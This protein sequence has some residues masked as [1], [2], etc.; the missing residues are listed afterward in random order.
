MKFAGVDLHKKTISICVCD[1]ARKIVDRYRLYCDKPASISHYFQNLGE[2]RM[3]VEAT[4]SYEWFVKLVEPHADKV[5]LAHPGKLRVI[6]ESTRKS[7]K[8]DAQVL[9][10]FLAMD[11]IPTS[12]R[13]TPRQRD[14]RRL[15]RQRSS[16]QRRI[17][18]VKNRMRRIMSDYNADR[19]DLFTRAGL[20]ALESLT[21]SPADKF[22]ITQMVAEFRLHSGQ[23]LE[24]NRTLRAFAA[25]AAVRE[26]QLRELLRTIPGVGFV[27]AEVVL[28]ELADIDRFHSQKQVVA[29]AGLAPGQRESAG[30]SKELHIE[31]TGSRHLRWV[32][33]EAAWRLVRL[34]PRWDRIF[35]QLKTRLKP[36]KAIVAVARR[37]LCLMTA[38]MKSGEPYSATYIPGS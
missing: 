32:L 27:T 11:M 33:V 9:A 21:F 6:A 35:E 4:A 15:V 31:K 28:A 7:D 16:I 26:R 13:P 14:H 19:K 25:G 23:L 2:F 8:L 20:A 1:Q 10:E 22:A 3:V 38:I 37:L 12:Y 36:K 5:L 18:A 30:K 17:T 29:Y 34:S 24:A